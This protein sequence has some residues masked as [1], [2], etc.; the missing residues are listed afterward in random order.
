MHATTWNLRTTRRLMVCRARGRTLLAAGLI[1]ALAAATSVS[2]QP[3]QPAQAAQPAQPAQPGPPAQPPADPSGE[4]P[5]QPAPEAQPMPPALELPRAPAAEPPRALPEPQ[6]QNQGLSRWE[7]DVLERGPI[8][9]G[10]WVGGGVLGT[11][12]GFGLGH[13]VQGR[14]SDSGAL[15]TVGETLSL[16]MM[17]TGIVNTLGSS[18]FTCSVD[19]QGQEFCTQRDNR[20]SETLWEGMAVASGIIFGVLRVWEIIDVWGGPVRI[21]AE[22]SRVRAKTGGWGFSLTPVPTRNGGNLVATLRF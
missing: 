1:A 16:A 17:I 14:W 11:W 8:S 5:A 10:A 21:N 13:A 20:T 19:A 7:Q 6:A 9:G 4:P 12:V 18:D 15:F 22:Y 2:A 3:A